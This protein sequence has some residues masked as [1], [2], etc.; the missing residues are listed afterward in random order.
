[1]LHKDFRDLYETTRRHGKPT[2]SHSLRSA[3]LS[4]VHDYVCLWLAIKG[5]M[6]TSNNQMS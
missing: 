4:I 3:I 1:M 2:L 5:R 6:L